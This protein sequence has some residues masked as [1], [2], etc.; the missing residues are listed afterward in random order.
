MKGEI[1]LFDRFRCKKYQSPFTKV[2]LLGGHVCNANNIII[3]ENTQRSQC[4]L[5][6]NSQQ[7]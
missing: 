7:F 4:R 5:T 3:F 2:M 6:L 1:L